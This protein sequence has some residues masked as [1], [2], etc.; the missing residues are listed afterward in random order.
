[1]AKVSFS[2]FLLLMVISSCSP[3]DEYM[4]RV[5]GVVKYLHEQHKYS[6]RE[7]MSVYLMEVKKCNVCNLENMH[8]ISS[9]KP[10]QKVVFILSGSNDSILH[11]VNKTFPGKEIFIDSNM[12]L[13]RYG[14]SFMRN[15]KADICDDEVKSYKFY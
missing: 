15:L 11:F 13:P 10:H 7:C 12:V 6:T 14:L 3:K 2:I 5:Q 9:E 8:R 4:E 1:M